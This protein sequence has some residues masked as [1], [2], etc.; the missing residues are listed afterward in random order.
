M[1]RAHNDQPIAAASVLLPT[2]SNS[3]AESQRILL[4]PFLYLTQARGKEIRTKLVNAFDAW[5]KVPADKLKLISE[6][7]EMLHTASLLIDDVEDG[8]D[9]RRGIP[10][11]SLQIP[12]VIDVFA[13]ELINLHTGQGMEIYWRD[14]NI[15]PTEK[16]YLQMISNKTGGLLRLAIK[17]MQAASQNPIDCVALVDMLGLHFQIRDDYLNLTSNEFTNNK[18]FAEDL[19]EGKFSYPVIRHIQSTHAAAAHAHEPYIQTQL[20][21]SQVTDPGSRQLFQILKQ[22]TTDV[23]LKK[24][25]IQTMKPTLHAMKHELRKLEDDARSEIHR[26][27]GNAALEKI[28]AYLGEA[29]SE[30]AS[31]IC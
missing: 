26:L 5:L 12:Q 25:A 13:Q 10:A 16:E 20:T 31:M 9:L 1:K 17:M 18:G 24:Y 23:D 30:S 29:Y 22:R 21:S 8:S 4:E 27:G 28:L 15:C 2:H 11:I 6:I 3:D 19:T 7:I 14:N